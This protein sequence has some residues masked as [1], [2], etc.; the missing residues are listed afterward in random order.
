MA[1]VPA[2]RRTLE[3]LRYLASQPGPVTV[4]QLVRDLDVPRSSIY[5]L[6][7]EMTDL[8]FVTHYPEEERWGL[9]VAAFEIGTAYLRHEPLERLA[10]PLLQSFV[11]TVRKDH[12]LSIQLGVLHGNET[13]YVIKESTAK[14]ITLVTDVGVRMPAALTATGRAMLARLPSE[15]IRALFPSKADLVNRTG[16]GP[17]DLAEL[18][19]VLRDESAQGFSEEDGFITAGLASVAVPV[20]DRDERPIAALGVTFRSEE[21]DTAER[22]G[23]ARLLERRARELSRRMGVHEPAA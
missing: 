14:P 3:L 20:I 23:L 8:G 22:V 17:R 19:R 21:V 15:Q 1:Q 10:R 4:G 13:L 7:R 12:A 16:K 2:A 5:H 18:R 9:G 6:L 11:R